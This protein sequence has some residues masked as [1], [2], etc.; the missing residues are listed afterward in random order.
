MVTQGGMLIFSL[1]E[2]YGAS[3]LAMLFIAFWE[4][5]TV[6]WFY[7][8]QRFYDDLYK[9]FGR[10]MNPNRG[11][12]PIFGY[13]WQFVTPPLCALVFLYNLFSWE[14]PSFKT[15]KGRINYPASGTIAALAL[16]FSSIIWVPFFMIKNILIAEGAT[17]AEK[18]RNSMKPKLPVD[19]PYVID[20]LAKQNRSSLNSIENSNYAEKLLLQ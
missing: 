3:G 11:F 4:A 15:D 20:E 17:I 16:M 5:V 6:A 10:K 8:R 13:I 9:M 1:V 14:T 2:S 19:H 7:G 18:F 12:W